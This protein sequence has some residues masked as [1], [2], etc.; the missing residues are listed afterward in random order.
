MVRVKSATLTSCIV[1]CVQTQILRT[2]AVL[3][4]IAEH[5][6]VHQQMAKEEATRNTKYVASSNNQNKV[7][8]VRSEQQ[9]QKQMQGPNHGQTQTETHAQHKKETKMHT[10]PNAYVGGIKSKSQGSIPTK[11]AASML[12]RSPGR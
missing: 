6:R 9:K 12:P 1:F 10:N 11:T 4:S 5:H 3:S 2:H 7:Q 8:R